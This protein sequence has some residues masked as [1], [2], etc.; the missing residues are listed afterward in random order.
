MKVL[1]TNTVPLN[2]GDEALL[3]AIM[4]SWLIRWPQSQITVLCRDVNRCRHHLPDL[5]LESDL[6]FAT[7]TGVLP[8]LTHQLQRVLRPVDKNGRMAG[9]FRACLPNP[10]R[11][12]ILDLYRQSDLIA[13]APGGFLHDHYPIEDRLRGFEVGLNLGKPVVILGQS[14]GP[15]WKK[16]SLRRIPQVLNRLSAICVRDTA[17]VEHLTKCGVNPE[18]I[19]QT[20]D[21]AFLWRSLAPDLY[22][23][24]TE[25]QPTHQIA[26]C[27]RAWPLHDA[28]SRQATIHKAVALCQHLLKDPNRRLGFISTCQ[29]IPG[30]IDDSTL[31]HEIVASLSPD[32]HARCTIDP[33]HHGPR[34][35]IAA[36][37]RYDAFIGMRLHG[38]LLSMLGGV[39][40]LGLGYEDK[41]SEIFHQMKLDDYQVHFREDSAAW[42]QCGDQFL[43]DIPDIRQHLPG[44]LD[45]MGRRA[46]IILDVVAPVIQAE[47]ETTP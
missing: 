42:I 31:A 4:E 17:S 10:G 28:D 41:T 35:L 5:N 37:S 47:A 2:G 11:K 27:F 20:A 18:L 29:G 21:A 30:Y 43:V 45:D 22:Q 6:E 14:I 3:R 19:H 34:E 15:F 33:A 25:N 38:C 1:L 8:A 39:P 44:V 7:Q 26:L 12:R 32:L 13:S 23:P 24:P 40:A 16:A 9:M 36:L 46:K